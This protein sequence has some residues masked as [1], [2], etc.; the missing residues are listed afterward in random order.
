MSKCPECGYDLFPMDKV[1]EKCG[2]PVATLSPGEDDKKNKVKKG[3]EKPSSK[4][5]LDPKAKPDAKAKSA[6]KVKSAAADG[7]KAEKAKS[8]KR[9]YND[10]IIIPEKSDR[11]NRTDKPDRAAKG[12]TAN[13]KD[14][15]EKGQTETWKIVV[16]AV[17]GF[18]VGIIVTCAVVIG[19]LFVYIKSEGLDSFEDLGIFDSDDEWEDE[20]WEDDEWED[21]DWEDWEDEEDDGE[22]YWEPE[23]DDEDWEEE[24]W[25]EDED[26]APADEASDED[27]VEEEVVVE[28]V[29]NIGKTFGIG[30]TFSYDNVR[31]TA[32]S[33]ERIADEDP[34]PVGEDYDEDDEYDEGEYEEEEE[35]EYLYQL[36]F[37]V[38]NSA[39]SEREVDVL[40][41]YYE[42]GAEGDTYTADDRES[43]A[44]LRGGESAD[45]GVTVYMQR[46]ASNGTFNLELGDDGGV[47]TIRLF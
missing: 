34:M 4:V 14:K 9:D 25:E 43:Y 31:Y 37:T 16:S 19:L 1:C 23:D 18:L 12:K 47:I 46:G 28:G 45:L 5:M 32:T 29:E 22:V 21:E 11:F 39:E 42:N 17:I 35:D 10:E 20:D 36:N 41:T 27:Y 2:T 3:K 6:G 26:I 15:P 30:E 13:I 7:I 40:G 8:S 38:V 24:D 44:T 33:F